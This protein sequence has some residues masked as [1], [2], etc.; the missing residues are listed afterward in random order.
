MSINRGPVY[1]ALL[2]GS[3]CGEMADA[4]D[5]KSWGRKKPCRFES[6]HRHQIVM[7]FWVSNEEVMVGSRKTAFLVLGRDFSVSWCL[8]LISY[9]SG[10]TGFA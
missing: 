5:L 4:Q 10:I 6:D 7:E 1:F 2:L 9:I 3:R 8:G